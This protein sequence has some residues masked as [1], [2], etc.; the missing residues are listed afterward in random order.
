MARL[1]AALD[2]RRVAGAR[3]GADTLPEI[4]TEAFGSS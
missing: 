4:D 1:D 3:Y 2:H